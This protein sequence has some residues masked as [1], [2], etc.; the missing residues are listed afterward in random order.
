MML[1]SE[2]LADLLVTTAQIATDVGYGSPFALST[3]FKRQ[4]GV[5]PSEYRRRRFQTWPHTFEVGD[6]G[7]RLLP[8]GF[9]CPAASPSL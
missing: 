3:A 6:G 4:F 9:S 8:C 2:S 7:L 5:S 1:A